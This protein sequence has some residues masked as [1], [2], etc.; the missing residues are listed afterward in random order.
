MHFPGLPYLEIVLLKT[1]E[2]E[3]KQLG[4]VDTLIFG[5]ALILFPVLVFSF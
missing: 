5:L 1:P 2:L 3:P 4:L